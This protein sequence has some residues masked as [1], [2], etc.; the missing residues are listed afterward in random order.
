M[1]LQSWTDVTLYAW[2][3]KVSHAG[4]LHLDLQA[5]NKSTRMRSSPVLLPRLLIGGKYWSR[6]EV[7]VNE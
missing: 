1:M 5:V 6:W 3:W 2:R 7:L 4:A